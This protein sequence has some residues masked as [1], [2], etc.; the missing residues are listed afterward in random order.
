[1]QA[2]GKASRGEVTETRRRIIVAAS[3]EFALH[4]Y[5]NA[6][7]RNIVDLAG[8]NL[9]AVNYHFGGKEGLYRATLGFLTTRKPLPT[10]RV[11]RRGGSV[12][13]RLQRRV[14][15]LLDRFVV[16]S[17]GSAL[18]R[19]LAH[20][21]MN[22]TAQLEDVIAESL[23]PELQR[24]EELL[25]QVAPACR[26][27]DI[28]A[29]SIGVLGQCLLYQFAQPALARVYPALPSGKELCRDAS[30]QIA[31]LTIGAIQAAQANPER[32]AQP[33][34]DFTCKAPEPAL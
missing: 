8:V 14:Y 2:Q 32:R 13:E 28:R 4:G 6:R 10:P 5:A 9:A 27:E 7:V 25:R 24:V 12:E 3:E 1:M 11:E 31:Q 30:R 33:R 22:P 20:E 21:A 18:G 29:A 19:I 23:R 15:R 17:Q 16:D 34:G 26:D